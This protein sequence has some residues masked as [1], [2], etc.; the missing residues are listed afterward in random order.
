MSPYPAREADRLGPRCAVI[1]IIGEDDAARVS[2][3]VWRRVSIPPSRAPSRPRQAAAAGPNDDLDLGCRA[4]AAR[5]RTRHADSMT[6]ARA[7][8][9]L[10]R[11]GVWSHRP[12]AFARR[13]SL[14]GPVRRDLVVGR[15][16]LAAKGDP[17]ESL[18]STAATSPSARGVGAGRSL[19]LA[20]PLRRGDGRASWFRSRRWTAR[21]THHGVEERENVGCA[22]RCVTGGRGQ[23][24]GRNHDPH[25][26]R[27]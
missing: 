24:G 16:R 2:C 13:E 23:P 15:G 1:G 19:P 4:A 12:S 10:V 27:L 25:P 14:A 6:R 8:M 22:S 20:P 5:P 18:R 26:D 3:C 9:E 21:A 11:G 17:G 7:A